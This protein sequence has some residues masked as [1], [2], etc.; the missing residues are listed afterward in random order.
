MSHAVDELVEIMRRLRDPDRGCPWD[1]KQDFKSIAACT[2][3][4]AYE[5]VE[6]IEEN[7]MAHLKEELGDLLMQVVFH[8]QMA[9]ELGLFT[10]DDVAR[11]ETEKMVERHPHVF[12]GRDG[13]KTAGDVLKNWEA[14]KHKKRAEAASAASQP[15]SLLDGVSTALPATVRALKL[16]KRAARVGFDWDA[17]AQILEK[18]R[19]ETDELEAEI[20]AAAPQEAIKGELGDLFFVLINLARKLDIDPEEAL[21]LTN[22]KFERRFRHIETSLAKARKDISH[23]TLEEMEALWDEA[24]RREKKD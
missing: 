11:I 15:H 19:E 22:R 10:I 16:Q 14:D 20:A 9:S 6:A 21:R 24:K 5:V 12:G 7:D 23:A 2:L 18:I 1:V 4:E 13:V 8:S 17:P 3:E